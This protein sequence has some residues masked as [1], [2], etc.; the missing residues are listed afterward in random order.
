MRLLQCVYLAVLALR[1]ARV[2]AQ[3]GGAVDL[4]L[5]RRVFSALTRVVG[6]NGAFN[7]LMMIFTES[8]YLASPSGWLINTLSLFSWSM[9]YLFI[10][11]ILIWNSNALVPPRR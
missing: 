8:S 7:R 10:N 3:S 11:G 6:G 4:F 5:D 9:L 1:S 2:L